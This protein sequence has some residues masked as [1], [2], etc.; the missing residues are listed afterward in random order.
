MFFSI[1]FFKSRIY[2][3]PFA[4]N[5]IAACTLVAY[6]KAADRGRCV[7]RERRKVYSVHTGGYRQ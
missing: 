5:F 4:C 7:R 6:A 1:N 3:A 2:Y